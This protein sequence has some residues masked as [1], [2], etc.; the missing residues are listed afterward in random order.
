MRGESKRV[1]ELVQNTES[2]V[3]IFFSTSGT[4]I[5]LLFGYDSWTF[6]QCVLETLEQF[7]YYFTSNH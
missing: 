2:L 4:F 7:M 6:I 5:L 1:S 3:S